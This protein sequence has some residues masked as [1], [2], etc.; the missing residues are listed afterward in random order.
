M[1]ELKTAETYFVELLCDACARFR[2]GDLL[3]AGTL[4]GKASRDAWGLRD[5]ETISRANDLCDA[6]WGAF[7]DL[8]W[9][10]T[11]EARDAK[12]A[13][14]KARADRAIKRLAK[15][16]TRCDH[17]WAHREIDSKRVCTLCGKGTDR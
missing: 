4:Y 3:S 11:C 2:E 15:G 7:W 9:R 6:V 16:R 1:E 17:L 10:S 5:R 12:E 14:D 8:Q 13:A